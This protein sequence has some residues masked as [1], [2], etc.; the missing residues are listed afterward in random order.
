MRVL[1]I[2]RMSTEDGPGLRT[3][4][5]F[6]GCP[7]RCQWCHNPESLSGQI[8]KE[9]IDVRCI[10]CGTCVSVCQ[11]HAL[12][13]GEEGIRWDKETCNLCLACVKACPTD[14]MSAMGKDITPKE[15]ADEL[16]KDKAYFGSEGGITFSGG[17]V[18]LQHREVLEVCKLLRKE[19]ISLA[20][21]TSGDVNYEAFEVLL[22]YVDLILYD[23]KLI[24]SAAHQRWCGSEN[25]IILENLIR[26]ANEKIRLWIRTPIIP[27]STDGEE[28]IRGIATF[29]RDHLIRFE[30]WEL[31]AFNN[32]CKDKY[33]RLG[34]EWRY[35][36]TPLETSSHMVKLT[37]TAQSVLGK[38][39]SISWTG[40]TRIEEE[41]R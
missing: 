5:F 33:Q 23:L 14:A 34:L 15:L 35:R 29:L 16:V 24:D 22:P 21:D 6:K 37:E 13:M 1:Q 19:G 25:K 27:D 36:D 10:R 39:E 12:T 40:M 3:T 11:R 28:N 38:N 31:C 2:Q 32:L 26:L 4:V 7:L 20:L 17:E 9:W 30:R 41:Q 8:Q 18:M